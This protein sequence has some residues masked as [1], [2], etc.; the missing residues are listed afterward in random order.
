MATVRSAL[1]KT[2]IQREGGANAAALAM[3]PVQEFSSIVSSIYDCALEPALWPSALARVRDRVNAAYVAI[4]LSAVPEQSVVVFAHSGW[5]AHQLAR[6]TREFIPTIPFFDDVLQGPLDAPQATLMRMTEAQFQATAFY[7]GWVKPNGLRD[8]VLCKFV[9]TNDRLGVASV[10]MG[11]KREPVQ[12]HELE[13]L[14]EL[15]PHLRRAALIGDLLGQQARQIEDLEGGLNAL[16]CPMLVCNAAGQ[17]LHANAAAHTLLQSSSSIRLAGA[18]LCAHPESHPSLERAL[19]QALELGARG[20]ACLGTRGIGVPLHAPGQ[21]PMLAYVLP[22]GRRAAEGV[23]GAEAEAAAEAVAKGRVAVFISTRSG[24]Q[25]AQEGIWATLFGLTPAELRV[26]A[27]LVQGQ[28][29]ASIA[30]AVGVAESTASTHLRRIFEKTA[31]QRQ[32]QLVAL[33]ASYSDVT[34]GLT[35]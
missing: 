2:L 28:S 9:Q 4:T 32:A 23:G 1:Q 25:A 27:R 13:F 20:D 19:A 35:G 31:T 12:P 18:Q 22:L 16:A 10:V 26:A 15:A 34:S 8:A 24:A 29:M 5:D 21:S 30:Q 3:T 17:V 14:A 6:L 7:Q 11:A 33:L